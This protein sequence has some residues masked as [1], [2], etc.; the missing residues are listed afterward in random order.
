[1]L[2]DVKS[3]RNRS[4]RLLQNIALKT[5]TLHLQ[6]LPDG[7]PSQ[8]LPLCRSIYTNKAH[9]REVWTAG[10]VDSVSYCICNQKYFL[11]ALQIA[12]TYT[13]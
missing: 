3:Y 4:Q 5:V 8:L 11:T 13:E 9:C 12:C 7:D 10:K 6:L 2:A 1:M